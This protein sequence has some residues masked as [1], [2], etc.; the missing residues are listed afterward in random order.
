MEYKDLKP[1][2]K[3]GDK[4]F[5]I[6]QDMVYATVILGIKIFTFPNPYINPFRYLIFTPNR[7]G[8]QWVEEMGMFNNIE[9]LKKYTFDFIAEY[10]AS[11]EDVADAN[12]IEVQLK[13]N[14]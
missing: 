3:I 13:M 14:K 4:V 12:A 6:H 9:D 11:F 10:Q 8:E 1:L 2:Y 7:E 5:L